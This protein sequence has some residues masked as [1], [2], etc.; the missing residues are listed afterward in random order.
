METRLAFRHLIPKPLTLLMD[1]ESDIDQSSLEPRLLH[2]VKLRASQINGCAYCLDMHSKD[3]R[4]DGESEQRLYALDAC[5]ETPF[6]DKR[7]RAAL[8]WTEAVTRVS[9]DHVPD[10][11]YEVTRGEFDDRELAYLTLA[12]ATI[13]A[14][15][16]LNVAL[17]NIPGDYRPGMLRTIRQAMAQRDTRATAGAT[18]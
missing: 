9:E 17:R 3:A 12:I 8:L 13:N 2:L 10:H 11:A 4:A 16:R 14:W 7:E 5:A 18:D 15:N 1:I 6:F